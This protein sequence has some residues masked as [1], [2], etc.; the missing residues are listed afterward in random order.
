MTASPTPRSILFV[1]SS[2]RGGGAEFV[3][4]TWMT[5]LSQRG[6]GVSAIITSGEIDTDF[7]PRGVRVRTLQASRGHLAKTLALN[8]MLRSEKP[9]VAIALQTYPNLLLLAATALGPRT[10]RPRILISE[11]N[12]VSLGLRGAGLSH[13]L[14]IAAAKCLYRFSDHVIAI[15]HPVAAELV[16]AFGV[17]GETVT[18]VPNPATAK[19]DLGGRIRPV[20]EIQTSRVQLVLAC[21]LVEQK[22]PLLAVLTAVELQKR[23]ITARIVSFGAGALRD[24]LAEEAA[25]KGIDCDFRGWID[26]WFHEIDADAVTLLPSLREGFGNVLVESAA[27]GCPAVAVSGALGVAD[28]IVPGITGELALSA[29]PM[30]LADAVLRAAVLPM[31]DL[32]PWLARFSV[33][34]SG[35]DLERVIETTLR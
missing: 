25:R 28:A 13:R 9:D 20:R 3:A 29:D 17:S 21:R 30:D 18:V 27:A 15:S 8:R 32:E 31:R 19:V 6:H 5:W 7:L 14:K 1:V 22:R 4:R 10:P 2:L 26:D 35:R 11:R 23:G 12:L 24:E 34:S 16:A 33:T